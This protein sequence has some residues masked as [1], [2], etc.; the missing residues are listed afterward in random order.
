MNTIIYQVD[1]IL[2]ITSP[3]IKDGI[4]FIEGDEIKEVLPKTSCEIAGQNI[5]YR[6]GILMPGFINAHT[7]LESVSNNLPS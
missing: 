6:S 4:V 3:P 1:W 7:H 2:P 5:V